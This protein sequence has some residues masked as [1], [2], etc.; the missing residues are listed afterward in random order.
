MLQT[1]LATKKSLKKTNNHSS[2]IK[3]IKNED[4]ISASME[5][6]KIIYNSNQKLGWTLLIAP[7][8]TPSKSILESCS[9]DSSKLLVIRKKHITDI[10]Y[11]LNSAI[12]NGNFSAIVTWMDV[13]GKEQLNR[14]NIKPLNLDFYC[15][16]N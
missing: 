11:V 10:E 15:F 9:I 6:L 14:L 16:A 12:A 2:S 1:T 3:Y 13:I 8:N 4:E 5:L 7:D